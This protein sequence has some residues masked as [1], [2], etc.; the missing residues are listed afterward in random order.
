[1]SEKEENQPWY[2]NSSLTM[3]TKNINDKK[4]HEKQDTNIVQ[5]NLVDTNEKVK[6]SK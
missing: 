2:I 3:D 5:N 4:L 1:M 6:Y